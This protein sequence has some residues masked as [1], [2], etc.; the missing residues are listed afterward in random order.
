MNIDDFIKEREE[1]NQQTLD[2][3]DK[4]PHTVPL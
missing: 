2:F 4:P 3:A 1:L